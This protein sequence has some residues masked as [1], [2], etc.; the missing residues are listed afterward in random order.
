[1]SLK[2]IAIAYYL[3]SNTPHRMI[4]TRKSVSTHSVEWEKGLLSEGKAQRESVP[5]LK[6]KNGQE[7]RCVFQNNKK[8]TICNLSSIYNVLSSKFNGL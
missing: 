5:L 6:V 4:R 2:E 7:R 1:M 3:P 8:I